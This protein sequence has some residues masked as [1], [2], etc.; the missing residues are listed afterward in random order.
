[1]VK[2]LCVILIYWQCLFAECPTGCS[3]CTGP[4]NNDCLA[5]FNGSQFR[6]TTN[7]LDS[8]CTDS[9]PIDKGV[10]EEIDQFGR[11]LCVGKLII[12]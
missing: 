12:M 6:D 3:L 4:R 9:C 1:M 11:R 2:Y 5:C 7:K 8:P 10:M